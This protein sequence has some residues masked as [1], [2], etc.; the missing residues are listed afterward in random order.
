[1]GQSNVGLSPQERFSPLL[2]KYAVV[3][4]AGPHRLLA[5]VVHLVEG[6]PWE[7]TMLVVVGGSVGPITTPF[8]GPGECWVVWSYYGST[9]GGSHSVCGGV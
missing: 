1:M 6:V 2:C 5:G 3:E 8:M 9:T 4:K 7:H